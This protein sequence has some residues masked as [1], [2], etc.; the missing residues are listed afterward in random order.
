MRSSAFS[1]LFQGAASRTRNRSSD[2]PMPLV[3]KDRVAYFWSKVVKI[4]KPDGCWLW[5]G[6]IIRPEGYGRF[7][8]PLT[9]S[10]SH[11]A[12]VICYELCKGPIPLDHILHHRKTCRK[13]CVNPD[14]LSVTTP[15]LHEDAG[16]SVNR[17]KTHCK[18]GHEFTP[19]NTYIDRNGYR[20]CRTCMK[21]YNAR[22]WRFRKLG[23]Y[24]MGKRKR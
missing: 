21:K 19:E 20:I 6:T 17:R 15:G 24:K 12:H 3:I 9:K 10:G 16:P 1:A 23:L 18:Y 7:Y 5:S 2:N 4:T 8:K 22:G 13:R 11:L 14:H